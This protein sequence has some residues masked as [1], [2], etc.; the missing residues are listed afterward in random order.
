MAKVLPGAAG[1]GA[2]GNGGSGVRERAGGVVCPYVTAQVRVRAYVCVHTCVCARPCAWECVCL[3][4]RVYRGVPR[5]G[6]TGVCGRAGAGCPFSYPPV[7]GA[8]AVWG[9][10]PSS[11]L[12][13]DLPRRSPGT[14]PAAA[15][16]ADPQLPRSCA[17]LLP[18]TGPAAPRGGWGRP[19][20]PSADPVHP[21]APGLRGNPTRCGSGSEF[22]LPRRTVRAEQPSPTGPAAGY[23]MF[24]R[25]LNPPQ[26]LLPIFTAPERQNPPGVRAQ[27][28]PPVA[29]GCLRCVLEEECAG[30]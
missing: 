5:V 16:G 29:S 27:E 15:P 18:R 20:Q 1:R 21:A 2:G 28:Q 8:G 25:A 4:P 3:C 26:V 22:I 17:A 13:W 24:L 6:G 23:S 10:G 30:R 7:R 12:P 9:A 11:H 14:Y 19:G